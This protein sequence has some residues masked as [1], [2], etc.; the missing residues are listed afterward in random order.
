MSLFQVTENTF[1]SARNSTFYF[2]SGPSLGVPIIFVHGWPELALSWRH[3]LP[4]SVR[5]ASGRSLRT[6]GAMEGRR[7][8]ARM[9]RMPSAKLLP[10]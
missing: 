7:F 10:T 3:Q 5:S 6:C 9:T 1:R 8:T 2:A 4:S